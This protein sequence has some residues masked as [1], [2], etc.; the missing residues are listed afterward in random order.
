M[1][2]GTGT[3][4]AVNEQAVNDRA[5]IRAEAGEQVRRA[6][7]LWLT[8]DR[9]AA[10]GRQMV[11]SITRY[12]QANR[13]SPT[14]AEALAGVD[15]A[16]CET[17]FRVGGQV[18]D[19]GDSGISG[20]AVLLTVWDRV[21]LGDDVL[22]GDLPT[23]VGVQVRGPAAGSSVAGVD[24]TGTEGIWAVVVPARTGAGPVRRQA[25]G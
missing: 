6:A 15:P 8:G 1:P 2:T 14:W 17:Q 24:G 13:R 25:V 23:P 22:G 5:A 12:R 16:L 20:H 21:S 7:G 9:V 10:L 19:Q 18:P 4:Q 3:E 11:L